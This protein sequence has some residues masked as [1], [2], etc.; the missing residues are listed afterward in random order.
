MHGSFLLGFLTWVLYS[1]SL[2]GLFAWVPYSVS[3]SLVFGYDLRAD[4]LIKNGTGKYFLL[5]H[6]VQFMLF[7]V[8]VC[9]I[10]ES[11]LDPFPNQSAIFMLWLKKPSCGKYNTTDYA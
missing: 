6:R 10:Y 9:E 7:S 5:I 4:I 3:F 8:V 1:G 2:F 11:G